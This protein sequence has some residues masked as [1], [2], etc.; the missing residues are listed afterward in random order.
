MPVRLD[1]ASMLQLRRSWGML[2]CRVSWAT[3]IF[4]ENISFAFPVVSI[5]VP[6]LDSEPSTPRATF[7]SASRGFAWSFAA[8]ILVLAASF[9]AQIALG[10]I[11]THGEFG[12][13]AIAISFN[14]MI[15]VFRDGGVV[16]WLMQFNLKDFQRYVG[17]AY[18]LTML[19]SFLVAGIMVV[20]AF[21]AG[22]IYG[23]GDA[24]WLMLVLA[25]SFPI[26]AYSAVAQAQLQVE[27]RFQQM[28]YI[29]SAYGV[30]RYVIAVVMAFAGF[31]SMSFAWAVVFASLLEAILFKFWSRLP[32]FPAHR[33]IGDSKSIVRESSWSLAGAS[34]SAILRQVDYAVLGL[35]V[36]RG[37]LGLYYF[38]FQLVMQPVLLINES[39][40][41]VVLPS[42]SQ[43]KGAGDRESRGIWYGGVFMGTVAAPILMLLAVVAAPLDQLLWEGKW[44]AAV[45]AIQLLCVAMPLH[46]VSLFCES[47]ASSHGR[48]RLWTAIG[49]LR[50][51]GTVIA[52]A[53]APLL[54]GYTNVAGIALVISVYLFFSASTATIVMLRYL[55]L[56]NRALWEGFF[57]PYLI[58][59]GIGA[60][61]LWLHPT[62]ADPPWK[63][64]PILTLLF[65]TGFGCALALVARRQLRELIQM[66]RKFM[67]RS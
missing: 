39:L 27:H 16:R 67:V 42:F 32:V 45:P 36:P 4:A 51:F 23:N 43:L 61:I 3:V 18:L 54:V 28:A 65:F 56:S 11:L 15:S 44:Q 10:R 8:G 49:F 12:T 20:A 14:D 35:L 64:I 52:A 33:S 58:S 57:P 5:F 37:T 26:G 66:L 13:Y 55:Q 34:A 48:F 25:I 21:A 46:L 1:H 38:A 50:G 6:A 9:I 24:T 31:G 29:K 60:G 7:S 19:F 22:A 62:Q 53:V 2:V 63:A 47:I 30:S 59:L 41:K 40:R 17:K